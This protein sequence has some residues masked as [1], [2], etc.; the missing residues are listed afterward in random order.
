MFTIEKLKFFGC[1]VEEGLARCLN[2]EGFY[3]RLVSSLV[4]DPKIDNLEQALLNKDYKR[5]FEL[6]HA[7]K[8]VYANLAITPLFRVS[9]EICELLRTGT[10]MDY[11]PLIKEL[12]ELYQIFAKMKED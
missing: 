5:G 11:S 4:P 8:G 10:D 3:L 7:L 9:S 1:N 12:K 2:D 6:A